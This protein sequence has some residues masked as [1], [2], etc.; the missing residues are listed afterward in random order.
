M[1]TLTHSNGQNQVVQLFSANL[2]MLAV[3]WNSS[4]EIKIGV[5]VLLKLAKN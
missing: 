4:E 2:M 1:P 5:F 3:D